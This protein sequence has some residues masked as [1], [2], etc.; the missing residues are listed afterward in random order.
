MDPSDKK[1]SR[2]DWADRFAP[3]SEG[4]M[5]MYLWHET[6]N[7][8][9][10]KFGERWVKAGDDPWH[11]ILARVKES[12]GVRKDLI[13][14]GV[15]QIDA[16]WD[17]NDYAQ[18]VGRAYQGARMD[19]YLRQFV[20]SRKGTTGEI[21]SIT[22]DELILKLNHHLS[23]IGQPLPSA[24]LSTM[25]YQMAEEVISSYSGGNRVVLAELCARFGKTL[26]SGAVAREMETPLVVVASYVK[27]VFASFGKDLTSFA[28][29]QNYSHVDTQDKLYKTQLSEALLHKKPAVAYLSMCPG[30]QREARIKY[31]FSRRVPRLLIVDEA[32]FGVHRNGQAELLKK[33]VKSHDK[34]LIMTG[35]NADRATKLWNVDTIVSVTYPELLV[36]KTLAQRE[37]GIPHA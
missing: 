36:Q 32:D 34:V 31:L 29:W 20:G 17:V 28:Q 14:T 37:L 26:F 13:Y 18:K 7:A 19:D 11:S 30:A 2:P 15:V 35:T 33:A 22:S 12:V 23:S 16:A 21:H 27:T 3:S 4:R 6:T 8:Q 25:Q 24:A 1:V 5:F 9:E 10:C